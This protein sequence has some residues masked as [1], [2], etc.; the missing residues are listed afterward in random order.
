MIRKKQAELPEK[1]FVYRSED[2]EDSY[3]LVAETLAEAAEDAEEGASIGSYSIEK[4]G[5]YRLEKT[6]V[7]E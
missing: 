4:T 5:K 3:L 7:E 2:G 6:A 1:V